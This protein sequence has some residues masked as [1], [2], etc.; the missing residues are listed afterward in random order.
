MKRFF[1]LLFLVNAA[2]VSVVANPDKKIVVKA[3]DGAVSYALKD[4]RR[5]TFED[6]VMLVDMKDGSRMN[7]D[8]DRVNSV[9]F[10]SHEPGQETV[11]NGV[12]LSA[13]FWV[14]DNILLVDCY[15]STRVVLCMCDGKVVYDGVCTGEFSLDMNSLSA[16]MYVL[17]LNGC[18]YKI[19][20]R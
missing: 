16:G 4:V 2:M 17:K 1:L 6:G 9:T 20:N 14:K 3:S 8:T 19:I 11:V 10:G 7:R 18:T 5:I 12:T 15:A 13:A